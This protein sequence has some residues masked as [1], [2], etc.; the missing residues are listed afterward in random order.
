[1]LGGRELERLQLQKKALVLESGLHRLALQ[2]DL[3]HVFS[4]ATWVG[5]VTR[6]SQG[7]SPLM[8]LAPV[9]GFF[10]ARGRGKSDS[11]LGRVITVAKLAAPVYRLWKRFR[12]SRKQA[13][14]EEAAA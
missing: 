6:R 7:F 5:E 14:A 9:L 12:S 2:A 4:G 3:R 8:A 10:L 11:W 1:V 13:E